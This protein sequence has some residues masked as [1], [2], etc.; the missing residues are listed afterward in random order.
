LSPQ[1]Q[2][3]D[4]F[5]DLDLEAKTDQQQQQQQEV[6]DV[7][8]LEKKVFQEIALQDLN[9]DLIALPSTFYKDVKEYLKQNTEGKEKVEKKINS[10]IRF[11][12]ERIIAHAVTYSSAVKERLSSE[13]A[14]FYER[15]CSEVQRY[16]DE[17]F[18]KMKEEI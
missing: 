3:D 11:R 10:F 18:T 2:Q 9:E 15:I 1:E 6:V 8:V 14:G 16:R 12:T 4:N 13:E 5:S 7:Q 17:I